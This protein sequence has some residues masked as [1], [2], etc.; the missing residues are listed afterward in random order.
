MPDNY[1]MATSRAAQHY[2][3]QV[4]SHEEG[5]NASAIHWTR[6][7]KANSQA[8]DPG[9]YCLHTN[10]SD[11]DE[12]TL[13]K[14]YTL[15]TE[16]EAVFRSLKGGL[17]LRPNYHRKEE[18]VE[19][20]LFI[21]LL[22]YHLVHVI[23]TQLKAQGIHDSWEPIRQKLKNQQRITVSLS[24]EAGKRLHIRKAT[25]P[26]PH[27]KVI[28]ERLGYLFATWLRSK[29]QRPDLPKNKIVKSVVP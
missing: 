21:T 16:L 26:E 17:G 23:R 22:A 27:Q 9:V 3:I 25:R 2:D 11:W 14:T 1:S 5:G 20:H 15:L 6:N 10:I 19:G 13:W 7:E 8:T 12:A 28:Y 29:K 24:C 18:R 4:K